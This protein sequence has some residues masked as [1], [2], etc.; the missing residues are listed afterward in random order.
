MMKAPAGWNTSVPASPGTR[1]G[2]GGSAC[3][4]GAPTRSWWVAS[5]VS[6]CCCS[7]CTIMPKTNPSDQGAAA[8]RTRAGLEVGERPLAHLAH[9]GAGLR[10]VEQRQRGPAGA[11]V[12]GTRRRGGRG[13]RAR[14]HASVAGAR[15]APARSPPCCAM[16]ATSQ[17]SGDISGE[18]W[19]VSSASSVDRGGAVRRRPGAGARRRPGTASAGRVGSAWWARPGSGG[20]GSCRPRRWARPAGCGTRSRDRLRGGGRVR[21]LRVTGHEVGAGA[22]ERAVCGARRERLPVGGPSADCRARR[23]RRRRGS[24]PR[25]TRCSMTRS[26]RWRTRRRVDERADRGS[27]A[28]ARTRR[29]AARRSTRSA[30]PWR[31]AAVQRPTAGARHRGRGRHGAGVEHQRGDDGDRHRPTRRRAAGRGSGPRGGP[32]GGP[33]GTAWSGG[34]RGRRG[35]ADV[36][37]SGPSIQSPNVT[38]LGGAPRPPSRRTHSSRRVER[39]ARPVA[40]PGRRGCGGGG[41]VRAGSRVSQ[42]AIREDFHPVRRPWTAGELANAASSDGP[43]S[44]SA[45]HRCGH[46][47]RARR[48]RRRPARRRWS[49]SSCGRAGRSGR[50][51]PPWR[52]SAGRR[53]SRRGGR[54]GSEARRP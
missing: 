21:R 22:G 28:P 38:P 52:R 50:R 15:G 51:R 43:S 37:D 53:A 9:V 34:S 41:L 13:P 40:R 26:T 49:T 19:R 7:C 20:P 33:A 48:R 42:L 30:S 39:P 11:R 5:I 24:G 1:A 8:G 10:R 18:C 47:R 44:C 12:A 45:A 27:G 32:A 35:W 2:G 23:D 31:A 14:R 54:S 6:T 17:S 3:S 36:R 25:R 4:T 16:C 46:V 29:P